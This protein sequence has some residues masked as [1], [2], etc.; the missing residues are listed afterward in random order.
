[1]RQPEGFIE[2]GKEH[3]VFRLNCSIYG[4]KQSPR[5][6]NHTLDSQHRE[7][8]FKP[9]SGDPCLYVHSRSGGEIFIVA[10][11]VDDL[12]L[13]GNS[14]AKMNEVKQELSLKFEM[15]DLGTLHFFLGVKVV[16]DPLTRV[17]WIG[18]PSYTEKIL[19]QYEMLD[20]KEVATPVNPDLKLLA[21]ENQTEVVNQQQYQAIVG[22]L[23]YLSTRTRPDIAYAVGRV[24]R[25]C[26]EP[27]QRH[28]V[29]VKRILRYLKG[30][31]NHGLSYKGDNEGEITGYSDADWGGDT[32]DK[33]STSGYV[34]VQA[35]A[36]VSW[37]SRKQTCVA[38]STAE[39]EYVA[40]SA[41]VQESLWLQQL[42]SDILNKSVR[43]MT[44]QEDNKST[45]ALAKNQH[46]HGRTKHIDIKYHFIRD[47]VESGRIKLQYCPSESMIADIFTKGLSIKQFE[48]L[49]RLSGVSEPIY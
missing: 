9:T 42:M 38:L 15:K 20:C 31:N 23:L 36:A 5:C 14:E 46:T 21:A 2:K 10:V 13:G 8:N 16:Q 35:G 12:I 30:T 18:Q 28:W 26:A 22:S 27:T 6:W 3:L 4:L 40:L 7:M 19:Q 43:L 34:F 49:R 17:I 47:M 44:L 48:N 41:A 32:G 11:Y 25:F 1:M 29:V 37:K 24:A 45:I 33:K 39:A